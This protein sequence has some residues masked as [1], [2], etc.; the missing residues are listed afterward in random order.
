MSTCQNV[1]V[2]GGQQVYVAPNGAVS[3]T[4]AHSAYAPPGSEFSG[5]SLSG[6]VFRFGDFD[7]YACPPADGSSDFQ[8]YVGFQ[9]VKDNS[10]CI[11]IDLEITPSNTTGFAAW[12]YT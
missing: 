11:Q 10:D 1:E 6:D 3:Y 4:Q 12:Q 9:Q 5:F 7:F 8:L 2:P